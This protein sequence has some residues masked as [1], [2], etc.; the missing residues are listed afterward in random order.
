MKRN[1]NRLNMFRDRLPF[2]RNKVFVSLLV[3]MISMI[4]ATM[5][6][7][8]WV[9][10]SRSPEVSSVSTTITANG[11]LEIALCSDNPSQLPQASAV[12]DSFENDG[13]VVRANTTWGNVINLYDDAYGLSDIVLRPA[14]LNSLALNTRPLLGAVYTPDGRVE[15]DDY[16]Q[17]TYFTYDGKK[18]EKS[19]KYGV[20]AIGTYTSGTS[21]STDEAYEAR[22]NKFSDI[23]REI[24]TLYNTVMENDLPPLGDLLNAIAQDRADLLAATYESKSATSKALEV[25]YIKK[26]AQLYT[27]L[28]DVFEMHKEQIVALANFQ[29]FVANQNDASVVFDEVTWDKIYNNSTIYNAKDVTS[30][31]S[32]K[33]I[34][35]PGLTQFIEDYNTIVADSNQLNKWLADADENPDLVKFY[36][37]KQTTKGGV[38]QQV[39]ELEEH[40]YDLHDMADRLLKYPSATIQGIEGVYGTTSISAVTSNIYTAAGW[41]DLTKAKLIFKGCI[42]SRLELYAI[43]GARLKGLNN[44]K[45]SFQ[46]NVKASVTVGFLPVSATINAPCYFYTEAGDNYSSSS[47]YIKAVF[48]KTAS[49]TIVGNDA[50]AQDTYGFAIDFWLRSNANSGV[51][52]A[53]ATVVDETTGKILRYDGINRIWNLTE[54]SALTT[55]STTQGSGSCYVYYADTPEDQARSLDLLNAFKIA[56]VDESG[57]LVGSA[58]MDTDHYW[59]Q[60]GKVTVPFVVSGEDNKLL[61]LTSGRAQRLTALFYLDG[62]LLTNNHVLAMNTIQGLVNLQFGSDADLNAMDNDKLYWQEHGVSAEVSK[63]EIDFSLVPGADLSTEIIVTV[64]GESPKKVEAFFLRA[65][66]STQ[67]SREPTM[68][69]TQV[70]E[71]SNEWKTTH[72]FTAPGTYWLRTVRLDGVDYA[73]DAPL[74]VTVKGYGISSVKWDE[75]ENESVQYVTSNSYS[76]NI[77]IGLSADDRSILPSGLSAIFYNESDNSTTV[78]LKYNGN[79]DIWEGT[80]TFTQSG[81]YTLRY[82]LDSNG[83]YISVEESNSEFVKK[84]TLYM[85]MY[86]DVSDLSGVTSQEYKDGNPISKNVSVRIYDGNY[87][88][89]LPGV[90]KSV[91]ADGNTIYKLSDDSEIKLYYRIQG[92]ED[93]VNTNLVYDDVT[94][95]YRGTLTFT[96]AGRYAFYQLVIT[97]DGQSYII[98]KTTSSATYL[99]TPEGGVQ[100]ETSS[101]SEYNKITQLVLGS[102][103]QVGPFSIKNSSSANMEVTLKNAQTN[104]ILKVPYSLDDP[105][106]TPYITK[107]SNSTKSGY[108][109]WYINLYEV[110]QLGESD[111]Q[112]V[113]QLDG[114]WT[115]ERIEL[116]GQYCYDETGNPT[117]DDG[118][119]RVTWTNGVGGYDFSKLS[120]YVT[121]KVTVTFRQGTSEVGDSNVSFFTPQTLVGTDTYVT[122]RYRNESGSWVDYTEKAPGVTLV[123][124]YQSKIGDATYGYALT[125]KLQHVVKIPLDTYGENG[126]TVST[127]SLS[128]YAQQYAGEYIGKLEFAGTINTENI[129]YNWDEEYSYKLYSGAPDA[130]KISAEYRSTTLTPTYGLFLAKIKP[131]ITVT[132]AISV[133]T[134][135]GTFDYPVAYVDTPDGISVPD[136]GTATLKYAAPLTNPRYDVAVVDGNLSYYTS[137]IDFTLARDGV[138]LKAVSAET[139]TPGQYRVEV[140]I[141]EKTSILDDFIIIDI[142]E[143]PKFTLKG[144][145]NL[146]VNRDGG[147]DADNS[148]GIG[149]GLYNN[150]QIET[151]SQ[152]YSI[153]EDGK[154]TTL[155]YEAARGG[156]GYTGYVNYT[157]PKFT[158]SVSNVGAN[159]VG[160]FFDEG[161]NAY[162]PFGDY[163]TEGVGDSYLNHNNVSIK[164]D[165]GYREVDDFKFTDEHG[166]TYSWNL[167]T[168]YT[169]ITGIPEGDPDWVWLHFANDHYDNSLGVGGGGGTSFTTIRVDFKDEA[170]NRLPVEDS[171]GNMVTAQK[172]IS[173]STSTLFSAKVPKN[174]VVTVTLS[175]VGG[176]INNRTL[177]WL[178]T[179]NASGRTTRQTYD[180]NSITIKG[181]DL[182]YNGLFYTDDSQALTCIVEG[183]LVTMADGTQKPIE[184]LKPG[185]NV[186]VFNHETG[187][188][189]EGS[190]WFID[191]IDSPATMHRITNLEFSDGTLFRISYQHALFDL[192]L[193]KYVFIN[194]ANMNEF[195]GH[196]FVN[197]SNENGEYINGETVLMRAYVTEEFTRVFGPISEYH[198][199]LVTDGLLTMP[200]F[201]FDVQGMINI[202]EYGEGLKYDEAKMQADIEK[203]GVFTYEE[204]ADLLPYEVWEK[205]PIAYFKVAIG[206]GILTWEEIEMT[207]EYL[208]NSGYVD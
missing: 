175:A 83:K 17:Y 9:T 84:L 200:S 201:N 50:V 196:R 184:D 129:T 78:A 132:Y 4:I 75:S 141:N 130:S 135:Y 76:T 81:T 73:L 107:K 10:L 92:M 46:L 197:V 43:D 187:K 47:S 133:E 95:A 174:A 40:E 134:A 97:I 112:V 22:K 161:S 36:V 11:N 63:T 51:L 126:W 115:V 168:P 169:A 7:F 70:S 155:Y 57:F 106:S 24:N 190:M 162:I 32:N 85:N 150:S 18:F 39:T 72:N 14:R 113:V 186:L 54:D 183:T 89:P 177:Y 203:Y 60:N 207:I 12:G 193:N 65:I 137:G 143:A 30:T 109:D 146:N 202:F 53:N 145:N 199:N 44:N 176:T 56:F 99:F 120:T 58:Y 198:F 34:S 136:A 68:M 19:D 139:L 192:D 82:I 101:T 25:G 74:T 77:Y 20:R 111:N 189:E 86:A 144:Q 98:D 123:L 124:T 91:D 29:L 88:Q 170:G 147:N 59:A 27:D 15:S 178:N 105:D 52:L 23:N 108:T 157:A 140:T 104:Q 114:K 156:A 182:Q 6:T 55:N 151:M 102:S 194:E 35:I 67:G 116:W 31:S 188:Y 165:G 205:A 208:F 71:G 3:F 148:N 66:T 173:S 26:L 128:E 38:Q 100:Y 80:A 163:T 110:M 181:D 62:M 28:I 125:N 171:S 127:A 158:V 195:I 138:Q 152:P 204:F 164:L 16:N 87:N 191:D 206:K 21:S 90:I 33:N 2:A 118:S 69:F 96:S 13:N 42:L 93:G 142:S 8:A 5:G 45:E 167:D 103:V 61:N 121:T 179:A 119:R 160:E 64:D 48:D 159:V 94:G 166:I 79:N 153:S 172:S 185:D 37:Y 122:V 117:S 154:T 1:T 41:I 131:D 149:N 180:S 49:E